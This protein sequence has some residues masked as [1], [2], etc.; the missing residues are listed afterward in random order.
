MIY[1]DCL[2]D[3]IYTRDLNFLSVVRL[4]SRTSDR[5]AKPEGLCATNLSARVSWKPSNAWRKEK[6][7]LAARNS[8]RFDGLV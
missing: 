8:S 2:I 6:I 5:G 7:L 4:V 3:F 1:Q